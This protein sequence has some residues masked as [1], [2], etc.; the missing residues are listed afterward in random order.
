MMMQAAFLVPALVPAASCFI[1]LPEAFVRSH[2]HHANPNAGATVLQL[3]WH[4]GPEPMMAHVGWVGEF[5]QRYA[6][7]LAEALEVP[8]EFG[9]CLGL[10]DAMERSPG[11]RISVAV[12]AFTPTVPMVHM[13]PCTADDWEIIQLHAGHLESEVL[14]Q[15]CVVQNGQE[16]PVRIQQHMVVHL[17]VTLPPDVP[18]ARLSANCE[19]AIAPKTRTVLDDPT[20]AYYDASPPLARQPLA[21][22][23]SD[24]TAVVLQL[25]PDEVLVHP[26]TYAQL[27][28]PSSGLRC[29]SIWQDIGADK[30]T[31]VVA[32]LRVSTSVVPQYVAVSDALAANLDLAPVTRLCLRVLKCPPLTP[33]KVVLT[34]PYEANEW[35]DALVAWWSATTDLVLE[36]AGTVLQLLD[37]R[38]SLALRLRNEPLEKNAPL[39]AVMDYTLIA[40]INAPRNEDV[41][42]QVAP[43]P[44]PVAAT[45]E[46]PLPLVW[47]ALEAVLRAIETHTNPIVCRPHAAARVL[48][49]APTPPGSV[50]LFGARGAGKSAL[51]KLLAHRASTSQNVLS[52]TIT[53]ACR[54][55]RGLKMES[56]KAKLQEA[57]ARALHFAPSVLFL[58][59]LDA[60]VPPEADDGSSVNDQSRRIAEHL[61]EL[62]KHV[63]SVQT[64]FANQLRFATP[65]SAQLVHASTKKSVAVVATAR[66][67]SAI[68][69]YLRTCGLFDRPIELA[70]PDVGARER[71]LLALWRQKRPH[72]S[73][74]PL[75][76]QTAAH[77]TEGFS[78]RDLHHVVERALHQHAIQQR[79]GPPGAPLEFFAGLTDFTPAALRGVDLFKSSIHWADVG[80]LHDVRTMLKETLELPTKYM[81]LYKAA[82][83][84]LPSGVLL[85]GPPGCGKT[86]LAN[87]VAS[88]C[89]LNFISVKGPEVLNKYIGASEQAVRDLF[90]RAA[91][92]APSVLFLDEFDAIAPRRGADNTGV[93]DRVVNQLLTFLDGVESRLGVYVLAATSRPDMIDPALLRPGRL[94]KSLYC[95]FPT[96]AERLDILKAVAHKMDVTAEAA[97]YLAVVSQHT[98]LYT[99]ADLQAIMYAA[100]LE[101]VHETLPSTTH[102]W[103]MDLKDES[104]QSVSFSPKKDDVAAA[105][106][107]VSRILQRHV[108]KAF[109]ASRPSVSVDAKRRYDHMYGSFNNTKAPRVTDFSTASSDVTVEAQRSA[110][111]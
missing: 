102:D 40:A 18:C 71:I 73:E 34:V 16:I 51:L 79:T 52:T 45:V 63:R 84:K 39:G 43:I 64:T 110:L 91:A 53:I 60:L 41:L 20:P 48:L 94:D 24:G 93:T 49:G 2:L 98:E 109:K 25:A 19:I 90:A 13:E 42:I 67:A 89:G 54:D 12:A 14:R 38:V 61:A 22:A 7:H 28:G 106:G 83:L 5:S 4:D 50:L 103:E 78:P 21:T 80:G 101:A 85:Y 9:R 55:L 8:M 62:L 65:S 95:G 74:E 11:L 69:P 75:D 96:M 15:I 56:V 82:P 68:H 107:G 104:D 92:A 77:K 105:V 46:K 32:R 36:P 81:K 29:V 1:A 23:L 44:V 35:L 10:A 30:P 57:F 97:A 70:L 33:L 100:Q 17:L 3:S 72:G 111:Y 31:V 27:D 87:A 59:D 86:M 88:E 58:D 47:P 99:G 6:M 108:E 76:A 37:T 66:D 26:A